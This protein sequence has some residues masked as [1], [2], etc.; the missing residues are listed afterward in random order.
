MTRKGE[1]LSIKKGEKDKNKKSENI[2]FCEK[3]FSAGNRL[4]FLPSPSQNYSDVYSGDYSDRYVTTKSTIRLC[5]SVGPSVRPLVGWLVGDAFVKNKEN[6]Y[7]RAND[8]KRRCTRQISC[9]HIIIQSFHHH[10]DASLALWALFSSIFFVLPDRC[11]RL[12]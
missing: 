7:F 9:N 2:Q 3:E 12:R 4:S 6:Q 1:N 11:G 8:W 10:E 5:P